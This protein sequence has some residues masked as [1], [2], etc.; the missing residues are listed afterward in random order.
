MSFFYR[1]LAQCY[2]VLVITPLKNLYM[3][4]PSLIGWHGQPEPQICAILTKNLSIHFWENNR[5]D[6]HLLIENRFFSYRYTFETALY[7]YL[8][9]HIASFAVKYAL[10]YCFTRSRSRQVMYTT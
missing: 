10:W 1:I 3:R 8:L 5:H 9:L 4:G 7:F 2:D 6:C